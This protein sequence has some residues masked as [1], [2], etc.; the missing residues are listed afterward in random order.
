MRHRGLVAFALATALV[1][2]RVA[3]ADQ[4]VTPAP[5]AEV[6]A[7]PLGPTLTVEAIEV[8]GGHTREK[9]VRDV[10]GIAPGERLA[11]SDP[12]L[13]EAKVRVLALGHFAAVDV[14]LRRGSAPGK[15]VLV[16]AV[17]ERGTLVLDHLFVGL[18][19]VTPW[20]LGAE[21]AD[22]NFLGSG[23]RVGVA[24]IGTAEADVDGARP[25]WGARL[26]VDDPS[27][28]GSRVGLGASLWATDASLFERIAGDPDTLDGDDLA[29]FDL[30]RRGGA[31][32]VSFRVTRILSTSA[33]LRLD[34]LDAGGDDAL[35]A[36]GALGATVDTRPDPVLPWRGVLIDASVEQA[37][38]DFDY[39]RVVARASGWLP[40]AGPTWVL[41]LHA[42]GGVMR[43]DAPPFELFHLADWN[44]LLPQR[45]LDLVLEPRPAWNLLSTA[46]NDHPRG[47]RAI[48]GRVEVVRRLPVAPRGLVY[49]GTVYAG[50][51]V[52]GVGA[53]G[54]GIPLDLTFDAGVRLDTAYGIFE[55]GLANAAG[56]LPW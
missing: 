8:T 2:G 11:A 13:V 5:A 6:D 52:F 44:P 56:R 26:R 20:W 32:R 50:V 16:V 53:D 28:F 36:T 22:A 15:V 25:Q 51:G 12:R 18:G 9:V 10:V 14:K 35:L 34:A 4:L 42:A 48:A 43:A 46:I 45:A 37:G 19:R 40:L 3:R 30:D 31:G 1:A 23:L 27:V 41:A 24:G 21:I 55:L 54:A 7:S 17:V 47:T 38:G 33:T 49:A 39:T 29:A